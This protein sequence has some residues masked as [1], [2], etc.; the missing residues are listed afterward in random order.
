MTDAF[1][2]AYIYQTCLTA[3]LRELWAG[4]DPRVTLS[5]LMC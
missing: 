3:W 4:R 1:D 2:D 5:F